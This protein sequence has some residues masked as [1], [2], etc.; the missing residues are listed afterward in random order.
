MQ[1]EPQN[2]YDTTITVEVHP[3]EWEGRRECW[4]CRGWPRASQESPYLG[5]PLIST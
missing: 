2:W 4:M 3:V 5:K 1:L